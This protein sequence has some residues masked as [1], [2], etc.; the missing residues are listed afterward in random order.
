MEATEDPETA[1]EDHRSGAGS[2]HTG[3]GEILHHLPLA[4]PAIPRGPTALS[5]PP[6]TREI[7]VETADAIEFA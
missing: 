7:E 6:T 1:A 2:H 4:D 3:V 5:H